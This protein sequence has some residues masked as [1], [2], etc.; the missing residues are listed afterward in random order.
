MRSVRLFAFLLLS[1]LPAFPQALTSI[2]AASTNIASVPVNGTLCLNAINPQR[3]PISV[4]SSAGTLYLAGYPFCQTLTAGALNGSLSVPNPLTD[5]APGHPYDIIIYPGVPTPGPYNSGVT[6]PAGTSSSE[7]GVDLGPVYGIGGST[8]SLDSYVPPSIVPTAAAFTFT[9][10]TGSAPS[11]CLSPA[12]D[13]RVNSGVATF[14]V[15]FDGGFIGITGGSGGGGGTG[16][17]GPAG[18]PGMVWMG[19]WSASASYTATDTVSYGGST[20]IAIASSYDNAPPNSTYWAVVAQIGATG[21]TGPSGPT[22]ATGAIGAIGS[23]GVAGA[24]GATGPQGA[25]GPTGSTGSQG[26]AGATGATG[27]T[28]ATGPQ[29]VAGATG[30]TGP[31]GAT[32]PTGSTGSQGVAGA[33]GATG[34]NNIS[35]N[36]TSYFNGVLASNG[37]AIQ[38]ASAA[39]IA[40]TLQ[41]QAGCNNAGYVWSPQSNICIALPAGASSHFTFVSGLGC[42][43]QNTDLTAGGGTD[44]TSCINSFLAGASPSNPLLLWQDGASLISGNGIQGPAGGNW[45]IAGNGGGITQTNITGCGISG[46]TATFTT[47]PNT[48]VIG[49]H[50]QLGSLVNCATLNDSVVTVL[51]AGLT[52]T[53]FETT[54]PSASISS[55]AETGIGISAYGTGFYLA[56]GS[57]DAISNGFVPVSGVCG[58]GSGIA[59]SRGANIM[60]RDFLLNGNANGQSNY[61]YGADLESLN[62]I[63]VQNVVFYNMHRYAFYGSND[64]QLSVTG[65]KFYTTTTG[66][67]MNTDGIHLGGPDNDVTISDDEFRTQDDSIALNAP[68]G[69]CGPISGVEITNSSFTQVPEP[70]RIY[71]NSAS[72]GTGVIPTVDTVDINNFSGSATIA[73]AS[74]GLGATHGDLQNAITNFKWTNSTISSP[75]GFLVAD[76]FGSLTFDNVTLKDMSCNSITRSYS[77][78]ACGFISGAGYD[79]SS[80]SPYYNNGSSLTLT[81]DSIQ[82]TPAG[83]LG[84]SIIDTVDAVPGSAYGTSMGPWGISL[85]ALHVNGFRISDVGGSYASVADAF[86]LAG[87]NSW[88]NCIISGVGTDKISNLFPISGGSTNGPCGALSGGW[89]GTLNVETNQT[90][91][92]TYSTWNTAPGL[93][94]GSPSTYNGVAYGVTDTGGTSQV[95]IGYGG[96][97]L[98]WSNLQN[99]AFMVSRG[100]LCVGGGFF[101]SNSAI[102]PLLL[103]ASGTAATLNSG[104]NITGSGGTNYSIDFGTNYGAFNIIMYDGGS[105]NQYGW[106]LTAGT[107]NF[108][109]APLS[110]AGGHF[111]FNDNGTLA[112]GSSI[113]YLTRAASSIPSAGVYAFSSTSNAAGTLDTGLSRDSA[114]VIDVG[115]GTQGNKSGSMNLTNLTV[116]GTCTGCGSGGSGLSGMTAGQV[117]IAATSSTITSSKALAGS[118]SGITTGPTSPTSGDIAVF[119]GTTGQIADSGQNIG[120]GSGMDSS[121]IV[122]FYGSGTGGGWISIGASD[123]SKQLQ[124]GADSTAGF[125]TTLS[126]QPLDFRPNNVIKATLSQAGNFGLTSAGVWG[127]SP[128][129]STTTL[130]T[131]L[132]RES[133]GVI[134][135]GNGAQGDKSGTINAANIP[136][137][138]GSF[139]ATEG[140]NEVN[141]TCLSTSCDNVRGQYSVDVDPRD[142]TIV[143]MTWAATPTVYVCSISLNNSTLISNNVALSTY[144]ISTTG[145]TIYARSPVSGYIEFNYYCQP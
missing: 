56:A 136:R 63:T 68:E 118:G 38:L 7:V 103:P 73:A 110:S 37:S 89:Q 57:G 97:N 108:T 86:N 107:M 11:S 88:T 126:N 42:A 6:A 131:G 111:S 112:I 134:D 65:S 92:I 139:T 15:C 69:Y 45:A 144:N 10:G 51:A 66:A 70:L 79:S 8:W 104:L 99:T 75:F 71:T 19:P 94:V 53:Q 132:S 41:D 21:A 83:H 47:A 76:N 85:G 59:P 106:G 145:M 130:D 115:N 74:L 60:L 48:L 14:S 141:L 122:R 113:S 109:V 61:C 129:T 123:A 64:G 2:T 133:A 28:G 34:P 26:V 25:T 135:V 67:G 95:G 128:S 101:T 120:S 90:S 23:Q 142:N 16:P 12:I 46:T 121:S 102:C 9:T 49:Q 119:T 117:P 58:P 33:T 22:G 114:G 100:T 77:T 1:S 5:S 36:T 138:T 127:W 140:T 116:T 96:A 24:T 40:A 125:M 82:R 80:S 78:T 17:T 35:I 137:H 62:D 13:V 91:N 27:T 105:N 55:A 29:G 98:F 52:T 93:N 124:F 20:Y 31:Q 54:V 143:T 44:D 87:T 81:N 30:A 4:T 43:H 84:S 32:G 50:M 72:C 18:A 3:D 39:Q